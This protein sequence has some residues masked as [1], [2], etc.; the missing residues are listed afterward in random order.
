VLPLAPPP[1][2]FAG[3]HTAKTTRHKIVN[4]VRVCILD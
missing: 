2:Q 3:R 4:K 1:P